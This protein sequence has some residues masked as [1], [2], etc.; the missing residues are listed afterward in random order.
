MHVA[1][2]WQ[3][4]NPGGQGSSGTRGFNTCFDVFATGGICLGPTAVGGGRVYKA[5]VLLHT[6]Q[7]FNIDCIRVI[8]CEGK[9]MIF[10]CYF[11]AF[12]G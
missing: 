7:V 10:L 3:A 9:K 5:G 2:G 4:F 11:A 6:P 1:L 8:I 12:N